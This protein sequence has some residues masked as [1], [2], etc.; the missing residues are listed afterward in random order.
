MELY[1]LLQDKVVM[2]FSRYQIDGLVQE[3]RNSIANALELHLSCIRNE[4]SINF[5][6]NSWPYDYSYGF[7][8]Q[9]ISIIYCVWLDFYGHNWQ[10]IH[11]GVCKKYD[12]EQV[13]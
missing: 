6:L 3:R 13:T 5:L 4:M 9:L 1:M 12:A 8:M 11:I 10:G 2:S 7:V